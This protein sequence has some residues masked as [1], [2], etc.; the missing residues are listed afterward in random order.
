MVRSGTTIVPE[1]TTAR[2]RTSRDGFPRQIFEPR[3]I[4]IL[5]SRTALLNDTC[6]NGCAALLYSEILDVYPP[7]ER[8]AVLSTHDLPRIQSHVSDDALWRNMSWTRYWAKDVWVLPIHRPSGVGHWVLC[9]VHL[10]SKA[11]HL[12]DSFAEQQPWNNDV[13]VSVLRI[14][15]LSFTISH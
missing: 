6:I 12:F 5:A 11:L 10:R 13:K 4:Q 7:A 3:D 15:F 1:R 14:L 8:Y 2:I 9:V